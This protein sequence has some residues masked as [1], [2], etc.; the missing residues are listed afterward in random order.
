MTDDHHDDP[1]PSFVIRVAFA[2]LVALF[3]A[4]VIG[5]IIGSWVADHV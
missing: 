3:A 4:F 5:F 1:S 2:G